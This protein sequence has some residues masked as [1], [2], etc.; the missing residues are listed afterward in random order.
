VRV[1]VTVT[2]PPVDGT[3]TVPPGEVEYA[4]A[5][6][7]VTVKRALPVAHE[8]VSVPDRGV[9]EGFA[10]TRYWIPGG[11]PPCPD[12]SLTIEIQSAFEVARHTQSPPVP[13]T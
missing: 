6:S 12:E 5:P 1:I 10:A 4:H 11:T 8:T 13:R 9:P 2:W 7:C 3:S